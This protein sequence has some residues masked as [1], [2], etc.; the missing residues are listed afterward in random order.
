MPFPDDE[1]LYARLKAAGLSPEQEARIR[2]E[3]EA[4]DAHDLPAAAPAV[5]AQGFA[6]G[7]RGFYSFHDLDVLQG[8]A[9]MQGPASASI[10]SIDELL[11]RDRQREQD[12]FPRKINV[13]RLIKPGRS[14]KEKVVIVPTTV[15]EKLLHDSSF[16][17]EEEQSHGGSGEGEEGEVIGEQPVRE[18]QQPGAAGP[19]QGEGGPHELE[20]NAYDLGRILTEK[21][22]LPHLKD[23]GKKRSLTR[24]TYDLTDRHRGFGQLLDKKATLRKILE[25]NLHLGNIPDVNQIDP[26]RFLVAPDDKVYRVLS[27]EKDYESQALVF[28][29]RDYSGSMEGQS[30]VLVVAQHVMIYSWLMYQYAMQVETRFILH[31]TQAKEVPDF[32]TYY[33]SKVAGGTQVSSAYQ[34][35][36]EIVERESLTRDYNIYIFHGTDGDDWD[37]DG[38]EAVPQ[39][40]RMLGYA[41]RVGIT[42]AQHGSAEDQRTEVEKY[43]RSSGLLEEKAKMLR[44]DVMQEDADE[45]RLIEG[46]KKLIAE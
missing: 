15:E 3:L 6:R 32:Y 34:L 44:M 42:I 1:K 20:S 30:T 27:P 28:F 37:H 19:G 41:N 2:R 13:G 43:V 8:L 39:L 22:Q 26:S 45:P 21:F 11:E 12:G 25:T 29:L 23:K 7:A 33:N 5:H 4:G 18:E 31:D 40:R 46:I 17:S 24:Y 10:R 38:S 36:N 9:A 16:R 35:V 14:G